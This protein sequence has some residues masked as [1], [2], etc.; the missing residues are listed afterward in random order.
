LGCVDNVKETCN[1]GEQ[2]EHVR[3]QARSEVYM[4]GNA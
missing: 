3:T 4:A 2:V 1:G